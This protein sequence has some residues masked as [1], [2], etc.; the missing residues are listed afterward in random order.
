MCSR[1]PVLRAHPSRAY[2]FPQR[3]TDLEVGCVSESLP[4]PGEA[5]PRAVSNDAF[6]VTQ[7]LCVRDLHFGHTCI[8]PGMQETGHVLAA[9]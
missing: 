6:D 3:D 1:S 8:P 4:T 5:K 7:L 2:E 9:P